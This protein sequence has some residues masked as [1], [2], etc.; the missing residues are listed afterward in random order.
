MPI[1]NNSGKRLF[2]CVLF[3]GWRCIY[4]HLRHGVYQHEVPARTKRIEL[5]KGT[6]RNVMAG[7]LILLESNVFNGLR[8]AWFRAFSY[9]THFERILSRSASD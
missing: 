1:S 4:P 2:A 3:A 7:G 9:F 8:Q 5:N 6:P